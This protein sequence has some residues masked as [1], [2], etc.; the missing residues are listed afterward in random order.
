MYTISDSLNAIFNLDYFHIKKQINN[1]FSF[2]KFAT[3]INKK[4]FKN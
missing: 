1:T 2:N 4:Y 3:K